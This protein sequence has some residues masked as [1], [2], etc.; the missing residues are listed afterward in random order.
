MG[1]FSFDGGDGTT[2]IGWRNDATI[3]DRLPVLI[4]NGLGTPPSAWPTLIADR[5]LAVRT[6]YYRGTSGGD[7]PAD[8]THITVDDHVADALALLDHEGIDRVVVACWSLGVNVGFELARLRPDRVAGLMAVAGVPGGTFAAMGA[9]LGIPRRLRHRV[10][11]SAAHAF[12]TAGP[13][14]SWLVRRTPMNRVTA[15]RWPSRPPTI[16]PWTCRSSRCR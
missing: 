16:S 13:A 11:L 7:R 3:D 1:R 4:C 9:P 8:R 12:R 5:G 6:W 2:V 10:A 14:V 15:T